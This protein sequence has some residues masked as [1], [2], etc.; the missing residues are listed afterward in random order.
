MLSKLETRA[1]EIIQTAGP[2]PLIRPEHL[3]NTM[4]ITT[5]E[6]LQILKHL[7]ALHLL[8][9]VA[10]TRCLRCGADIVPGMIACEECATAFCDVKPETEKYFTLKKDFQKLLNG[11][12]LSM[13]VKAHTSMC[14]KVD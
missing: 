4:C 2:L 5:E 1:W 14:S 7:E 13:S 8:V 9:Q 6:V 3:A 11:E 10:V 12:Q